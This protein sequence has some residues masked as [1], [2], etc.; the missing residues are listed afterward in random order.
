[1]Q[2]ILLTAALATA[3]LAMPEPVSGGASLGARAGVKLNQY[4][5]LD[6]W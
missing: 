6:D 2:F 4:A 1:M 3:A 5:N